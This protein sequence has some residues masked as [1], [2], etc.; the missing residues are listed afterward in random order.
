MPSMIAVLARSREGQRPFSNSSTSS[1]FLAT[2]VFLSLRLIDYK[3]GDPFRV[4]PAVAVHLIHT[5]VRQEAVAGV[6]QVGAR[7]TAA[8][9][10][11]AEAAALHIVL[12]HNAPAGRSE[13][14]TSELQ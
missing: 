12:D 13:E 10:P 11:F 3:C 5:A 2:A 14:H 7:C 1:L 8:G 9:D 4:E 6:Q